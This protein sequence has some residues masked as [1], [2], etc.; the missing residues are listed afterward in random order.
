MDTT[1]HTQ[2]SLTLVESATAIAKQT[3]YSFVKMTSHLIHLGLGYTPPST[4]CWR[5]KWLVLLV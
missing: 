4:P 5:A 3:P 2:F 1:V